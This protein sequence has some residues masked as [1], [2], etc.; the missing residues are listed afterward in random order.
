MIKGR[1]KCDRHRGPHHPGM[2]D[3]NP[4]RRIE[5][6]FDFLHPVSNPSGEHPE[7]FALWRHSVGGKEGPVVKGPV[8]YFVPHL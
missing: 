5:S 4:W 6:G 1:V 2:R 7:G 3:D 8:L